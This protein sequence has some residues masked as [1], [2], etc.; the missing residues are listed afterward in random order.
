MELLDGEPL[1]KALRE[2][3]MP[4]KDAVRLAIQAA[5]RSRPRTTRASCTAIS[6]PR[7]CF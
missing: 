6:S 4:W 7:T 5:Q 2:A 1:D 3:A